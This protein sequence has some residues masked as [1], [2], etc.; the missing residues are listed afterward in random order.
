MSD[1]DDG[2]TQ[3][4]AVHTAAKPRES[5]PIPPLQSPPLK[6]SRISLARIEL[7]VMERARQLGAPGIVG[8]AALAFCV[9]FQ[10]STL[11][12]QAAQVRELRVAADASVPVRAAAPKPA[13]GARE[14]ITS[15][16]DRNA[17]PAI[18]AAI[19]Q[20]AQA[21]GLSLDRGAYQWSADKS[22]TVARYQLTL[23]V[24]GSYPAVRQFVD[25]TLA[26][27]PAAAL[28]GITLERPNVGDGTVSAS[29]RFEIFTRNTP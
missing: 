25:A 7:R 21:A 3:V 18:L 28:V 20:Q 13:A 2:T 6:P 29:L 11:L 22:G 16:P 1:F 4:A 14:F 15:L 19:V 17:L 24:T 26:A 27:V 23:P 10:Q 5:L 9:A 8:I 12:P